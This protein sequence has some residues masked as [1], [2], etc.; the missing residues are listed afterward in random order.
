MTGEKVTLFC[1]MK[2]GTPPFAFMWMKNSKRISEDSSIEIHQQKD[3]SN[4]VI[5]SLTVSSR[6]NYTCQVSNSYGS[7]SY[8]EFLN[9]VGKSKLCNFFFKQNLSLFIKHFSTNF[10]SS[11]V[12]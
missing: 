10:I 9:V 11:I 8:T 1:A 3:Y 5:P 6:G 4:L 2:S 7:D 12:I